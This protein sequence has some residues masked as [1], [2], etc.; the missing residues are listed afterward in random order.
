[1]HNSGNLEGKITYADLGIVL[2][3]NK[4]GS[5]VKK[6]IL[7]QCKKLYH[8][9]GKFSLDNTYDAFNPEQFKNIQNKVKNGLNYL[10]LFYH[11]TS[12]SFEKKQDILI[13]E[14]KCKLKSHDFYVLPYSLNNPG[15]KILS[16]DLI[17]KLGNKFSLKDCYVVSDRYKRDFIDFSSFMIDLLSCKY[18]N[19]PKILEKQLQLCSGKNSEN[20]NFF[21]TGIVTKNTLEIEYNSDN[22]ENIS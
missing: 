2:N 22:I 17:A 19:N 14:V 20:K 4:P 9:K 10:Y 15:I 13:K 1:V 6:G 8:K 16:T 21:E 3:I 7:I 12:K 11:P 18:Q 5:T